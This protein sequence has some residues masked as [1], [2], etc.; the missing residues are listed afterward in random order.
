MAEGIREQGLKGIFAVV[1]MRLNLKAAEYECIARIK[2]AAKV[3]GLSWI[4][5]LENG[6]IRGSDRYMGRTSVNFAMHV[7]AKAAGTTLP[8]ARWMRR[9]L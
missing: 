9:W 2:A 5:I 6:R 7:A 1:K 4:E 3:V 8:G